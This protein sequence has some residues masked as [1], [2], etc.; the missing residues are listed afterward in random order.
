MPERHLRP[1]WL[2]HLEEGMRIHTG[3]CGWEDQI[4][5]PPEGDDGQSTR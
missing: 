5:E 1:D 3:G 4:P 2:L